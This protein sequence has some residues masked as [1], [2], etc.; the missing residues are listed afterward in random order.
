MAVLHY[1]ARKRFPA[2]APKLAGLVLLSMTVF[3]TTIFFRM[4]YAESCFFFVTVSALLAM[5]CRWPLSVVAAIIALATASRPVGVALIP[6]FW[7]HVWQRF[8]NWRGAVLRWIA[9]TPIAL[10]GLIAYMGYQYSAFGDALAFAKTQEHWRK[11]GHS[12]TG[13]ELLALL[14]HEPIWSVYLS[15]SRAY[16]RRLEPGPSAATN[17]AFANPIYF[18]LAITLVMLG[19]WKGWLNSRETLLAALLIFIPYIM[20]GHEMCMLSQGRFMAVVFP[21]YLVMGQVLSRIPSPYA[22]MVVGLFVFYLAIYSMHV[23]AG[24]PLI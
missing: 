2:A 10:A 13:E 18:L 4:T 19:A 16:W 23:A 9:F 12:S 20:R 8:P 24:Y 6:V 5:E 22:A 15:D 1:Y 14:S 11:I 3:P 21:I 7:L 17:L